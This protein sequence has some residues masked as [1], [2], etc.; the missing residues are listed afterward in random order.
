MKPAL[1]ILLA[2]FSSAFT[3]AAEPRAELVV[4]PTP[5]LVVGTGSGECEA[6]EL[7]LVDPI[8]HTELLLVRGRPDRDVVKVIADISAPI[9]AP[10]HQSVYFLS[11]AYAVTGTVKRVDLVTGMVADLIDGT[12]VEAIPTGPI[13]GLLVIDRSLI[14]SD[15]AGRSLGRD[16]YTWL[17][18]PDGRPL[19]EI[20]L[21]DSAAAQ[22]FRRTHL[23]TPTSR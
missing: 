22:Q 17:V 7:W 8:A 5:H 20:G 14:K 1:F 4:R 13:A 2:L 12:S 9:F 18:S 21:A 6:T 16:S 15:E 11:A 3:V 19:S 23:S 10:D